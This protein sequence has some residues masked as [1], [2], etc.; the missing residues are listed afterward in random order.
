M[1]KGANWL[2]LF[3]LAAALAVWR[4]RR[5][6][7]YAQ[8]LQ[9]VQRDGSLP[10]ARVGH[11]GESPRQPKVR[12]RRRYSAQ[13]L[14]VVVILVIAVT[15][16]L[17]AKSSLPD[18]RKPAV[19]DP[20]VSGIGAVGADRP[21]EDIRTAWV[22][23]ALDMAGVSSAPNS[24]TLLLGLDVPAGSVVRWFIIIG[25]SRGAHLSFPDTQQSA[26]TP[27]RGGESGISSVHTYGPAYSWTLVT[28][29]IR[30]PSNDYT[31]D[32]TLTPLRRD[33]YYTSVSLIDLTMT[34][35]GQG[36]YRRRGS[37]VSVSGFGPQSATIAWV[38]HGAT[39]AENEVRLQKAERQNVIGVPEPPWRNYPAATFLNETI[40]NPDFLPAFTWVSG[41]T[42][43]ISQDQWRWNGATDP[44]ATGRDPAI[45]S[46][47]GVALFKVGLLVGI[48]GAA[49]IAFVESFVGLVA[50]RRREG[51]QQ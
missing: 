25:A 39:V 20:P 1:R 32:F 11:V 36:T 17:V 10:C 9:P 4:W 24:A 7:S 15:A 27:S 19:P 37:F 48:A 38:G 2:H 31:N 46:D 3:V 22:I 42:A 50:S 47:N 30:G 26:N 41:S 5:S 51:V 33:S 43:R 44:G 12:P 6:S 45:D 13:A 21:G 28:G 35:R 8:K 14:G 16:A 18:L 40:F 34:W 23:P 29:W 49:L